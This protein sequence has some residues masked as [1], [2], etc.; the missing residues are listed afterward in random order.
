M[1]RRLVGID[2]GVATAH[3]V[4]VLDEQSTVV[5]RRRCR[6]CRDS[7]EAIEAAALAGAP[8]GTR[9]EVIFE[10]TGAAWLPVAVFF[11][12]RGHAVHRVSSAKASDLRRFLSRHAKSN[13]IDA[14]TLARLPLIDPSGLSMVELA[15]GD[16][17]SLDRRV[18]AA[19][20]L[21]D[22]AA[23]H[24]TRLRD[25]ARQAMPMLEDALGGSVLGVSDV[26]VLERY[27]DPRRMLRAGKTRLAALI[28]KTSR[29]HHG[30][31]RAER[32]LGVA[33]HALELY[34]DDPAVAFEDLAAE[35]ATEARLL[36]AT[37]AEHARHAAVREQAYL[38]IDP[39]QLARS[40]PGIATTGGPVLVSVMGR[41][42]RF[43]NADAF[44]AFTGLTPRASQ[45]GAS[46][47]KGQAMTKAGPRRL[48]DQLV[49][50]ANS[51]RR[52]DPQLAAVYW[53][54][55]V[56]RGAHH[57][58]AV[59]VVAARLAARAWTVMARGEP[60]VLR[61]VDGRPVDAAQAKRIIAERYT[62]TEHVRRRRRSRQT[63][64]APQAMQ[65]APLNRGDL[66]TPNSRPNQTD[67]SRAPIPA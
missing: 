46:D 54:Q 32:W 56:E 15:E 35:M 14:E 45:T 66:P 9:L 12:R 33:R 11:T 4:V 44:K 50:S 43:P 58:K 67:T 34:S 19:D 64:K 42:G 17:A 10:P 3:T 39:N 55:M 51:A 31:A 65:H 48:R 27:G 53:S 49:Q 52:V 8:P 62:V 41:P 16:H 57:N 1:A 63:G 13:A 24:K 7:L 37:E 29:G 60:Y 26:A 21:R 23:A 30:A 22:R 2:L 20:R 6:P 18:R 28:A 40:L 25:L 5:A 38:R 61:D 59:C 47:R 36:R